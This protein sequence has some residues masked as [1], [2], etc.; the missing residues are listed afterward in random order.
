[1][2]CSSGGLPPGE[3]AAHAGA[4][5]C[6]PAC[7]ALEG[8]ACVAAARQQPQRAA[9]LLGAAESIRKRAG[10]PLP[11]QERVDVDRAT[12]VAVR[13]LGREAFPGVLERGRR[14]SIEEA[15]GYALSGGTVG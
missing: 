4:F 8:L 2:P 12:D 3:P 5:R 15:A 13:A 6:T 1:M 14:M 11:P 10:T 7:F 9:V